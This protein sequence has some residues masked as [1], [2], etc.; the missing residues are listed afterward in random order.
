[1]MN[2]SK[3]RNFKRIPV[4]PDLSCCIVDSIEKRRHT[5]HTANVSP[6]GLYF[7]T[8]ADVFEPGKWFWGSSGIL[9]KP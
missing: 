6:G 1:M 4:T 8:E 2:G 3:G 5:S 9:P 7:Q